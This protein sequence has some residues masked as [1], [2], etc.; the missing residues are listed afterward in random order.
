MLYSASISTALASNDNVFITW[1]SASSRLANA[2]FIAHL[3][4][5]T[6]VDQYAA[7]TTYA[8]TLSVSNSS[9]ASSVAFAVLN[10]GSA[11]ALTNQGTWTVVG[12]N[13]ASFNSYAFYKTVT[14][15]TSII[16][17]GII[18]PTSTYNAMWVNF[19]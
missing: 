11:G 19:K 17:D 14:N 1:S 3:T 7:N 2:V 13:T 4:G 16:L 10:A 18:Y 8:N 6:S 12:T 5:T 15:A 9:T